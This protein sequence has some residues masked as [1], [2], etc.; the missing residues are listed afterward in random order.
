MSVC[1]YRRDVDIVCV[2]GGVCTTCVIVDVVVDDE[3][4]V[5]VV[6]GVVVVDVGRVLGVCVVTFSF[7]VLEWELCVV[8]LH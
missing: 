3:D 2:E 7:F 8:T 4:D 5:A 6:D 1:K